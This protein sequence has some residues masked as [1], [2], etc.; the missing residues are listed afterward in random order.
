MYC[1]SVVA[2]SFEMAAH[3]VFQCSPLVVG[4]SQGARVKQ[5]LLN[6]GGKLVAVP[7]PEMI[8]LVSTEKE[9][10]RVKGGKHVV[11]SGRPLWHTVVVSVF[12]LDCKIEKASNSAR[13][14]N[15]SGR[16]LESGQYGSW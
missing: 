14:A 8:E 13:Y 11:N 6:V 3:N 5:H 16:K 12:R 9:P 15:H 10:F 2:L 7:D 4:A 1:E